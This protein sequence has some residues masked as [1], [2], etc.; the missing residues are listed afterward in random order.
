[1]S[2][3][4]NVIGWIFLMV[5]IWIIGA[6]LISKTHINDVD[7]PVTGEERAQAKATPASRILFVVIGLASCAYG[8]FR[9][10]R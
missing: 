6:G 10:L 8:L 4:P 2:I 1:M 3:P 9:I 7:F 5:G